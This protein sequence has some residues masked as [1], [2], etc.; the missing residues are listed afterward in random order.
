MIHIHKVRSYMLKLFVMNDQKILTAINKSP[1]AEKDKQYWKDLLSKM[2]E[3]QKQRF[4]HTVLVKTDIKRASEEIGSALNIINQ[5]LEEEQTDTDSAPKSEEKKPAPGVVQEI[6]SNSKADKH[7]PDD[8]MDD[9][10]AIKE[11]H[12]EVQN[13]LQEL[14][15]ELSQISQ[16]VN[17]QTPPS[18]Q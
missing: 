17:G 8:K 2:T 10:Q 4:Y 5:A 13:R 3:E 15:N 7:I 16:E 12:Q 11:K 14:R 9:H 6:V 1:L 18:Y